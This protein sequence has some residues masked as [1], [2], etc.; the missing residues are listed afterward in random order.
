MINY[1]DIVD[2]D[3]RCCVTETGVRYAKLIISRAT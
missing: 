2:A 3:K 1:V